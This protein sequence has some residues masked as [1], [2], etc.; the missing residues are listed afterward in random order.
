MEEKLVSVIIA[1]YNEEKYVKK[2]IDSLLEQSYPKIEIILVN[3]GSTDNTAKQIAPYRSNKIKI[4]TIPNSGPAIAR[5]FGAKYSR[6]FILIFLDGDM[7]FPPDYIQKL[8]DPIIKGESSGSTHETEHVANLENIWAKLWGLGRID[9]SGDPVKKS[10]IYRAI[11][12]QTFFAI[13]G[14]DPNKDYYDDESLFIRSKKTAVIAKDAVCYHNNP[15]DASEVLE[16]ISWMGRSLLKSGKNLQG[17]LK[18]FLRTLFLLS[19][20]YFWILM[21]FF[22]LIFPL[23]IPIYGIIYLIYLELIAFRRYQVDRDKRYFLYYPFYKIITFLGLNL[24]FLKDFARRLK[25][26]SL[27]DIKRGIQKVINFVFR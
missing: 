23:I 3:D 20:T 12:R 6:G 8:I 9:F 22:G 17:A 18:N 16:Q 7:E 26:R 27:K 19:P 11:L 2:C 10:I 25:K 4:F 14:Y 1:L 24:G 13:N 5:N 15:S 21:F